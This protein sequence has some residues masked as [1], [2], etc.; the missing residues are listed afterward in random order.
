MIC[1]GTQSQGLPRFDPGGL[2]AKDWACDQKPAGKKGGWTGDQ[3]GLWEDAVLEKR[4]V[5]WGLSASGSRGRVAS[6]STPLLSNGPR[7]IRCM[8]PEGVPTLSCLGKLSQT[9]QGGQGSRTLCL[10]RIPWSFA[11]NQV[12]GELSS[13]L[14]WRNRWGRSRQRYGL[15]AKGAAGILSRLI[16]GGWGEER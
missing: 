10:P 4:P 9:P 16:P 15:P 8:D 1:P 2:E 12:L 7:A 5:P 6:P 14:S 13:A 3:G 11:K